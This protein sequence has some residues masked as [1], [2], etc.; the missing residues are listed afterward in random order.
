M[1]NYYSLARLKGLATAITIMATM[2]A[3]STE[4]GNPLGALDS[5]TGEPKFEPDYIKANIIPKQSTKSQIRAKFGAPISAEDNVGDNSA[6]WSYERGESG[7]AMLKKMAYKYSYKYGSGAAGSAL[8]QTDNHLADAEDVM[9]DV[10]TVTGTKNTGMKKVIKK[11]IVY[12]NGET[13]D[14]FYTY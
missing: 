10:S 7:V 3:C 5:L 8:G 13:V 11:I 6:R 4:G 9:D 2:T 14:R 1:G 12:F